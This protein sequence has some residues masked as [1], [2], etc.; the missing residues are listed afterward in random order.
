MRRVPFGLLVAGVLVAAGLSDIIGAHAQE[1]PPG[2]PPDVPAEFESRRVAVG[3]QVARRLL[4]LADWCRGQGMKASAAGLYSQ[5][6]DF[7][8]DEPKA[9]SQLGYKNEG[10]AWKRAGGLQSPPPDPADSRRSATLANKRQSLGKEC[11][12]DLLEL[13]RWCQEM[14]LDKEARQTFFQAIEFDPENAPA[15]EAL[16]FR[17]RGASWDHQDRLDRIAWEQGLRDWAKSDVATP[18]YREPVKEPSE[19]EA[20]A[21]KPVTAFRSEHFVVHSTRGKEECDHLV[22]V[23][24]Q[25]WHFIEHVLGTKLG[26]GVRTTLV[27]L[28]DKATFNRVVDKF[29]ESDPAKAGIAKQLMSIRPNWEI[30][31]TWRGGAKEMEDFLI[32]HAVEIALHESFQWAEQR[33]W[34]RE[35]LT[36][37]ATGLMRGTA[38]SWCVSLK[39]TGTKKE[40]Y[41]AIG[42]WPAKVK[43]LVLAKED[44]SLEFI[45]GLGSN[46]FSTETMSKAWSVMSWLAAKRPKQV[47]EFLREFDRQGSAEGPAQKAFSSDLTTLD[48]EWRDW[49]RTAY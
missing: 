19:W 40:D 47:V 49:I 25:G 1:A 33:P 7:A 4:S 41:D 37:L 10:G 30:T 36:Y 8:P 39:E 26:K 35:G 3:G 13:G 32:H 45:A 12:K 2:P 46:A 31:L 21:G 22:V 6:L 43:S 15:R 34:V 38:V 9:R 42:K 23:A 44:E 11:A 27:L 17:R 14:K 28:D 24:E 48:R 18:L 16:G 5:V 29:Y 20:A